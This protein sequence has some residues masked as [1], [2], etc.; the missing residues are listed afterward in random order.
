VQTAGLGSGATFPVGTT[1]ETYT[2]TDAAGNTAVCSFTVTVLDAEDPTIVCPANITVNNDPGICGAIVTYSPP[3]GVDNC[4][5][6]I[7]VQT[8]GLGSGATFPVGTTTETYTVTDAAGNTAVCSFTVTVLDSEPPMIVC[9]DLTIQLDANGMASISPADIGNGTTDNCQMATSSLD[10]TDFG[11]QDEGSPNIVTLDV[12]DIYGNPAQCTAAVTVEDNIAPIAICQDI[13]VQLDA[14]GNVMVF[15]AQLDNG[16]TDACGLRPFEELPRNFGCV[17]VGPNTIVLEVYDVNLNLS[18]CTSIVT[19][20]DNVAPDAICADITIELDPNGYGSILPENIDGGSTDACG[21]DQVSINQENF[22][23]DDL[24]TPTLVT[25]TITDINGN[26]STCSANVT[27]EDNVAPIAVCNDLTVQLDPAGSVD[28]DVSDVSS[29]SS[30]GCSNINAILNVSSFTC[31]D[32]GVN[33]VTVTVDDNN[34]NTS[35]CNSQITVEDNVAPDALCQDVNLTLA[36]NGQIVL[37]AAEVNNGS[38]D[39]CGIANLA[40][41]N[42]MFDCSAVGLN[43]TVVLTVTDN[44]GN[45]STCSATVNVFDSTPPVALCTDLTV[46]L[47]ASG[48]AVITPAQVGSNSIDACGIANLLL[49]KSTFDCGNV[50]QNFVTL[51]VID[52]SGNSDNCMAEVIVEDNVGPVIDCLDITVQLD[53]T[54][55]VT[56]NAA[57]IGI[58]IS[59]ACGI[60]TV[61]ADISSFSC[62]DI[63]DNTVIL[64]VTDANGNSNTCS[65]VVTV[66]NGNPIVL[67]GVVI[68]E[69]GPGILNGAIDLIV[70]GGAA[71][72][73]YNWSTGQTD[74]DISGLAGLQTYIVTVTDVNGCSETGSFIVGQGTGL[75]IEFCLDVYLGGMFDP[76]SFAPNP[77]MRQSLLDQDLIPLDHPYNIQPWLYGGPE[78]FPTLQDLPSDMSDW[79][80]LNIRDGINPTVILYQE[81][82]VL[83]SNGSITSIDGSLPQM[84]IGPAQLFFIELVHYNH[85][86]AVTP[87]PLLPPIAGGPV[88]HDFTTSMSQAYMDPILNDDPLFEMPSVNG[89]RFGMIPGNVQNLDFQIDAN[90]VNLLFFHYLETFVYAPWDTNGDGLVD[91]NDI[92]VLFQTYNRNGHKPY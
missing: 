40:L 42:D 8:A 49:D 27:V 34:G 60:G 47:N 13:T 62:A 28:I 86:P 74:Q 44:N 67:N 31:S 68:D 77:P 19:V 15:D 14:S 38:S 41:D 58:G 79:M 16:S 11:C 48:I 6:S 81:A 51:T 1:T 75:V 76:L 91:V 36:P 84:V 17:D 65:A 64:T 78:S 63:G 21:I 33:T 29:A 53:Q 61:S 85:F 90:D 4:P 32:I 35:T 92:N 20:E 46:Q 52:N 57:D 30:D 87:Q 73:Q 23:C 26:Q 66:E 24:N 7:T 50:G 9:N 37:S 83:H 39:A 2:V 71:P 69:T 88:C 59:D 43:S 82:V 72:Y 89:T 5:G 12:V 45:S 22:D 25:L 70:G 10:Q 54:G 3:V 56:I 18:T 55:T 80:L